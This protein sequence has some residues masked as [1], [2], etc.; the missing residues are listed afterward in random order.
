[1]I[2]STTGAFA[3]RATRVRV[4]PHGDYIWLTDVDLGDG[5]PAM[6]I[7]FGGERRIK[8]GDL[9]PVAPPGARVVLSC[10]RYG[11]R[12]RKMRARSYRGQRSNGMLCS[13]DELGWLTGGPNEVAVLRNVAI[14]QSLDHLGEE[15]WPRVVVGWHRAK[16]I[17]DGAAEDILGAQ[18]VPA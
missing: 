16:A 1:M 15:D 2:I 13:L 14:G 17:A 18:P 9:V 7:V 12:V 6:Q 11:R 8:E 4:H 3:G 10:E 5:T